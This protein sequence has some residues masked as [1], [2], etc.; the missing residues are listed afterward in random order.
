MYFVKEAT[1]NT[2]NMSGLPSIFFH[3]QK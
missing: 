3:V 1:L 2:I